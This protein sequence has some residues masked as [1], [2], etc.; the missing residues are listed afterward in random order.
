M[1]KKGKVLVM[2]RFKYRKK[3][4]IAGVEI[5]KDYREIS[6]TK[7][8]KR[9]LII[10]IVSIL[11]ITVLSLGGA[12]AVFTTSNKTEKYNV[13]KA[14]TLD[15]IF[16]ADSDNTINLNGQFP[17][18]DSEGLASTPYTF[19]IENTGTLAVD[20]T[21]AILDDEEMI[22]QDNCS[23][24]QLNKNYVKYSLNGV[25]AGFLSD[26]ATNH[27][28]IDTSILAAGA[29]RTYTIRAWIGDNANNDVFKKHFHGKIVVEGVNQDV[30]P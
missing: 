1:W 2:A 4:K 9:E 18:S 10:T 13:I 3:Y 6:L 29:K 30:A 15:I 11:S 12:F 14:G 25:S 7:M 19:T 22:N 21:V 26:L 28:V 20:Y 5:P 23:T 24:V 8:A 27:Y 17:K 16:S